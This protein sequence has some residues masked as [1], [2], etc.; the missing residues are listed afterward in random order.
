MGLR[1]MTER[2]GVADFAVHFSGGILGAWLELEI[3]PVII[4]PHLT[5]ISY[6]TTY[7][8]PFFIPFLPSFLLPRNQG[9]NLLVP[10]PFMSCS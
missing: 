2:V 8:P 7:Y 10:F 4:F 5:F 3:S 1:G 6:N 9:R